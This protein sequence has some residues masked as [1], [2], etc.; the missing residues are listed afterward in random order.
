VAYAKQW[1]QRVETQRQRRSTAVALKPTTFA[2]AP[3][4]T[5]SADARASALNQPSSA[6]FG[7][8]IGPFGGPF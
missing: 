4:D 2:F 8:G 1:R 6:H 3:Q 5:I 7:L